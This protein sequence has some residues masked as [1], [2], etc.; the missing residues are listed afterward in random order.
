MFNSSSS[1]SSN[2][3]ELGVVFTVTVGTV[4]I[5]SSE[6]VV[7]GTVVVVAVGK[8]RGG[9]IGGETDVWFWLQLLLF[10]TMWLTLL[11]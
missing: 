6:V 8:G 4:I 2:S 7:G 9:R 3:E 5:T 1:V 11:L 10:T